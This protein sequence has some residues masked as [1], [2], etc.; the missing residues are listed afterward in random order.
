MTQATIAKNG[1]RILARM[2][3]DLKTV[4]LTNRKISPPS[5]LELTG[6]R[7]QYL[8]TIEKTSPVQSTIWVKADFEKYAQNSQ[9]LNAGKNEIANIELRLIQKIQQSIDNPASV[10]SLPPKK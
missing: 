10:K 7:N 8:L 4:Y 9:I 5:S 2:Q 6:F 1:Y 3:T